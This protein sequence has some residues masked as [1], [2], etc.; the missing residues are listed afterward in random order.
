MLLGALLFACA[1]AWA[2]AARSG[3]D[4]PAPK[5]EPRKEEPKDA[6]EEK[7][8]KEDKVDPLKAYRTKGNTWTHKHTSK[9]GSM[10]ESINYVRYEVTEVTDTKATV[11][12]S[13]LDRDEKE[14]SNNTFDVTLKVDEAKNPPK[15][16]VKD[17]PKDEA[18]ISE[19]KITVGAGEFTCVKRETESSGTKSTTW[20]DKATQLLVKMVVSS[21]SGSSTTELVKAQIK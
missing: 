15:E 21:D 10:E 20:T 2:Q 11:K 12:Q 13:N 19:E 3:Q 1:P 4:T 16:D 8:E 14:V 6:K 5:E 17:T 18:K 9:Y 7:K